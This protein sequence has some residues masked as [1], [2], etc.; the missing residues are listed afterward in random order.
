MAR[1]DAA[2][3]PEPVGPGPGSGVDGPAQSE[4]SEPK[5][6]GAA[7]GVPVPV[8]PVGP[9][10][11]PLPAQVGPRKMPD[12]AVCIWCG[13]RVAYVNDDQAREHFAFCTPACKG[14]FQAMLDGDGRD[15]VG[16]GSGR[17][18]AVAGGEQ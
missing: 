13:T 6:P 14:R 18:E 1:D 3:V 12:R 2:P 4:R 17:H 7:A 10:G 11:L 9:D 5:G 8:L 16:A 15:T